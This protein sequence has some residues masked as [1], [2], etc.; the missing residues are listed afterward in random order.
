MSCTSKSPPL[1]GVKLV[2]ALVSV[3]NSVTNE[4]DNTQ[5]SGCPVALSPSLAL[6]PGASPQ[7]VWS[8]TPVGVVS[9]TK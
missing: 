7:W 6:L 1:P 2:T 8:V 9:H 4:L 5:V 3:A